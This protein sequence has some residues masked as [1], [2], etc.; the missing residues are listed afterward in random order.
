[1]KPARAR[2]SG[3]AALNRLWPVGEAA[4]ADYEN[5]RSACW[6]VW[7]R[8]AKQRQRF[9]AEGLRGLI[10]RPVAEACSLPACTG[11]PGQPGTPYSDPRLEALTDGLRLSSRP[12]VRQERG[13][14]GDRV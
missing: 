8:L 2:S 1:V 14:P 9:R 6:L 11:P 10:R 4:Q 5:L 13:R 12:I 7:L 3:E